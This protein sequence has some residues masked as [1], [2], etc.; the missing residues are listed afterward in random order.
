MVIQCG[1]GCTMVHVVEES[2]EYTCPQC[3]R[4]F[5]FNLE[6]DHKAVTRRWVKKY[7]RLQKKYQRKP[8]ETLQE[9]YTDMLRRDLR[10]WGYEDYVMHNDGYDRRSA[11]WAIHKYLHH[12][13]M[14]IIVVQP[15]RRF[16]GMKKG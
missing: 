13:P 6:G 10:E 9:D 3:G 2:C 11:A 1:G 7:E 15:Y 4:E 16:W 8:V 12:R 14:S 5:R